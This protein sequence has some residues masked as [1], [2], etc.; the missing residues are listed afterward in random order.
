MTYWQYIQNQNYWPLQI[1]QNEYARAFEIPLRVYNLVEARKIEEEITSYIKQN[2][3]HKYIKEIANNPFS[4]DL[5][6]N[7]SWI[8]IIDNNAER[9]WLTKSSGYHFIQSFQEYDIWKRWEF[10]YYFN[11][12]IIESAS[13][14]VT[15][16]LKE[17]YLHIAFE[18]MPL[19]TE[20]L[21]VTGPLW[22]P[23]NCMTGC[24]FE[25]KRLKPLVDIFYK[26]VKEIDSDKDD[27]IHLGNNS[28]PIEAKILHKHVKNIVSCL[29]HLLSLSIP[30]NSLLHRCDHVKLSEWFL[31]TLQANKHLPPSLVNWL[32]QQNTTIYYRLDHPN[33]EEIS[34]P[35]VKT[36][37]NSDID[38]K[39]CKTL[40]S[41]LDMNEQMSPVLAF[42]GINELD[43]EDFRSALI[44]FLNQSFER[45]NAKRIEPLLILRRWLNDQF[46]PLTE[47]KKSGDNSLEKSYEK[48]YKDIKK[49]N[50]LC[51]WVSTRT[52]ANQV[53]L[54][55]Y[56]HS[57]RYLQ[58][59]GFYST[60]LENWKNRNVLSNQMEKAGNN[61]RSTSICYRCI[62]EHTVKF[63][64]KFDPISGKSDPSN[65]SLL[66]PPEGLE[67]GKSAIAAPILV[68]GRIW[69]VLEVS[70]FYPYQFCWENK[71]IIQETAGMF[72]L[73][74]Y[75]RH[76]LTR[77]QKLHDTNIKSDII[78]EY[79]N[80]CHQ[81]ADIFL[82][83]SATLWLPHHREYK[84]VGWYNRKDIDK[85]L[86]K[87]EKNEW[88]SQFESDIINKV[89]DNIDDNNQISYQN[90]MAEDLPDQN[91]KHICVIPIY[92][93]DGTIM[94]SIVLYNQTD[95]G[96]NK[97][98]SPKI[99]FV[100]Q[101]VALILEAMH[102]Q[103]RKEKRQRDYVAHEMKRNATQIEDRVI[104][105]K[106]FIDKN[107]KP[108]YDQRPRLR[109]L[110]YDVTRY[111]E[112]LLHDI[113]RFSS[114]KP[115]KE[116]HKSKE[117]LNFREQFNTEARSHWKVQQK[118]KF[119]IHYDYAGF[120]SNQEV[121]VAIRAYDFRQIL[122][123]LIDNAIK[124]NSSDNP[125]EATLT[126]K[127]HEL[128]FVISNR[129]PC[130]RE[131]E[132]I[133]IFQDG[134]RGIGAKNVAGKGKGLFIAKEKCNLYNIDFS[135]KSE[136]DPY[137]LGGCLHKLILSFP[138]VLM[139]LK[140]R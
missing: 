30:K 55:Y 93:L 9:C 132:A 60:S 64:R 11:K 40:P 72:S 35:W 3:F 97:K 126:L 88:H 112:D 100:K 14:D 1:I 51:K 21:L 104:N 74:F 116:H 85:K 136:P 48:I 15:Y 92:E 25:E 135:Y 111:T 99:S 26:I 50:W 108:N 138:P 68:H 131:G 13:N 80:I 57:T 4:E 140:K 5:H 69:G 24:Y 109:N 73:F 45:R 54:Y 78:A 81:M 65:E 103:E 86:S 102:I 18:S 107:F 56:D 34:L 37:W 66:L 105:I 115:D 16:Y 22:K 114:G 33:V 31:F 89:T 23:I 42:E 38:F 84:C 106:E 137:I 39:F 77:L 95:K 63:T 41:D 43:K 71:K 82:S 2:D 119:N 130:L 133:R 90:F 129:Y 75:H 98:W 70:G 121:Y 127:K 113:E 17:E 91:F 36:Q 10:C 53:A 58:T 44:I 118:K 12:F 28:F 87:I 124:Y 76:F 29:K 79:K 59:R 7:D 83:H 6:I 32:S 101:H 46:G 49:Y 120:S 110:R 20:Y 62:D 61:E 134:F 94:G 47:P 19:S 128:E 96:F 27:F 117:L 125:I 8:K 139:K 52:T 67:S 123:N 122:G